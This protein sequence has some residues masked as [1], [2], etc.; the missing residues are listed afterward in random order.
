[1]D[2]N[3]FSVAIGEANELRAVNAKGLDPPKE[4]FK[5][6]YAARKHL[7]EAER[8]LVPAAN[9]AEKNV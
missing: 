7:S 6:L 5:S 9:A 8:K 4:P 2:W 1:M 3:Q